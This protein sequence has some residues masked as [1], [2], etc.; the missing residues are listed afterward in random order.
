MPRSGRSVGCG[1]FVLSRERF[2][3]SSISGSSKRLFGSGVEMLDVAVQEG[4]GP[5]V[6]F[7]CSVC[8]IVARAVSNSGSQIK[9]EDPPNLSI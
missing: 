1:Q 6:P 8:V 2:E 9:Q 7:A 5:S 3:P 4:A